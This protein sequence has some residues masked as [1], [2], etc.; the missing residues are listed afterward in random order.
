LL[1][2]LVVSFD[3]LGFHDKHPMSSLIPSTLKLQFFH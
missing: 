3:R 2:S 1:F